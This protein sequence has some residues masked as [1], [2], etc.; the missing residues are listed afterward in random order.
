MPMPLKESSAG[1]KLAISSNNK[2]RSDIGSKSDGIDID[3]MEQHSEEGTQLTKGV[4][5]KRK[6]M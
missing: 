1:L 3:S 5:S 6:G 4:L 2:V